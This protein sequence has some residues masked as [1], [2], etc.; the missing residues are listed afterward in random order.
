MKNRIGIAIRVA[1]IGTDYPPNRLTFRHLNFLHSN[2]LNFRPQY[3]LVL[4][5]DCEPIQLTAMSL[6]QYIDFG[7]IRLRRT[8]IEPLQ[9]SCD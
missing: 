3:G 1:T 5:T 6:F 9:Y 2:F 8:C 4:V 7:N